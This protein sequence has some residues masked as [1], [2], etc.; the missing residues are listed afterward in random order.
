MS[1]ATSR[2]PTLQTPTVRRARRPAPAVLLVGLLFVVMIGLSLWYL[3]RREPLVMQGEVQSRTFDMAARVDGR[4]GQ[5]RRRAVA[6]RAA[7][8]AAD[9]HREP[10]LI[11]KER[12]SQAAL[13]GGA[14]GTGARRAG[15]RAETIAVRKAEVE[16]AECRPDA[17]AENIRAQQQLVATHDSPQS[18]IRQGQS[19]A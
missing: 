12:Q 16:R 10:E 15:F 13:R 6:G 7:W 8:G 5:D 2:P 4:I 3:T 9:P 19:R 18:Q 17:G 14:G 1:E 11:A